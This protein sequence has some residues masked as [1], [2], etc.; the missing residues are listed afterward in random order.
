MKPTSLGSLIFFLLT[1]CARPPM[2]PSADSG[3]QGYIVVGPSCPVMQ[4]GVPC[5]DRPYSATLS[6]LS[7]GG[8]PRV[9]QVHADAA[10]YY[11]VVLVPGRY[12]LHPESQGALPRASEINFAV[13]AHRFTRLDVVYDSGIR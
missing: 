8:V 9:S 12:V 1:A 6:I 13:E 4:V 11:R 7:D 2:A 10:G 3:V 5:P